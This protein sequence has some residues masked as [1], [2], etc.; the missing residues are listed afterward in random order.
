MSIYKDI[1]VWCIPGLF[2]LLQCHE[3]N[4]CFNKHL[5]KNQCLSFFIM[6]YM[7]YVSI[8]A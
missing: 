5:L 2:L 1:C 3:N 4:T 6:Y 8:N 7:Y